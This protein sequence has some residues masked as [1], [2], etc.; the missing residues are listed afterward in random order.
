MLYCIVF[1]NAYQ[2]GNDTQTGGPGHKAPLIQGAIARMKSLLPN[3]L[4]S[5]TGPPKAPLVP[6]SP[7][8]LTSAIANEM[9]LTPPPPRC[10]RRFGF[11]VD[12]SYDVDDS[13]D[14]LWKMIRVIIH[15]NCD[16]SCVTL[17]DSRCL[18]EARREVVHAGRATGVKGGHVGGSRG[19]R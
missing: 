15:V 16:D 2:K 18:A 9:F 5:W 6:P 3:P 8:L 7:I 4:Q 14:D 19:S 1:T 11:D 12:D 17:C 10:A 13:C